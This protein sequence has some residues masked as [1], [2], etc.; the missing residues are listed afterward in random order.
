M[1]HLTCYSRK[2]NGCKSMA[3]PIG[4][5]TWLLTEIG[6]DKSDIVK[7]YF[8]STRML[9]R[10]TALVAMIESSRPLV[11]RSRLPIL[12]FHIITIAPLANNESHTL[13]LQQGCIRYH[14]SLFNT[15]LDRLLKLLFR[16]HLCTTQLWQV[17]HNMILVAI[18]ANHPFIQG[19]RYFF[20]IAFTLRFL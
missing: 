3:W 17:S 1:S 8:H 5:D 11:G 4:L 15:R 6:G 12:F 10:M 19:L 9:P 18:I 14:S 2:E 20:I 7:L 13:L 16:L